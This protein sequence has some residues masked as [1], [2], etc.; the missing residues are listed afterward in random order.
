MEER[1]REENVVF[2]RWW[3][4]IQLPVLGYRQFRN[5]GGQRHLFQRRGFHQINRLIYVPEWDRSPQNLHGDAQTKQANYA[6]YGGMDM[7]GGRQPVHTPLT[8]AAFLFRSCDSI[9][10]TR[11][12]A[13]SLLAQP[14]PLPS[15][16]SY[17]TPPCEA[18]MPFSIRP[19]R[20]LPLC[21]P[22][23]PWEVAGAKGNR[24]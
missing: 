19:Y 20:R 17:N 13:S 6:V 16:P 21:S 7:T 23:S 24:W 4:R 14:L 8:N 10:M 3:R 11:R 15:F 9:T 1:P 18:P 2:E 5:S 22:G 12:R